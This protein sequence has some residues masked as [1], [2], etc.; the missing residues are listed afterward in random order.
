VSASWILYGLTGLGVSVLLI[1]VISIFAANW[2][3]IPASA[4]LILYFISLAALGFATWWRLPMAG[5]LKE[6]LIT[7]FGLYVLAGIGLIGQ[8][9]HLQSD[10]YS[11]LFLW[12][13]LILP[14]SLCTES[15]LL[16]NIWFIGLIVAVSLWLG[17]VENESNFG[18]YLFFVLALPHLAIAGGYL[19]HSQ[20]P[21]FAEAA[22]IWGFAVLLI[23]FAIC[24]NVVWGSAKSLSLDLSADSLSSWWRYAPVAAAACA[25][26]CTI[27]R[28]FRK[29]WL[30]TAAILSILFFSL[31]LTVAPITI[32]RTGDLPLLGCSLFI[33]AWAGA[34]ALAAGMERRRLFDLAA[35]VIGV[36]FVVVYF[37][38]FGSLAATGLGLILSGGVI[39]GIS[40]LW[41]MFRGRV[42]KA[43]MGAVR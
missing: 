16:N 7:A 29:G 11:A 2:H 15:R 24:G 19:L 34:A 8:T 20:S 23:P 6:A 25:G 33:L 41:F 27:K 36:R 31:L 18:P 13:A 5:A 43:L 14:I 32:K 28:P 37:E 30:L 39:L 26:V 3:A 9:Y 42:Q 38:V 40:Y 4:K 10:G 17:H 12:L 35:F 21:Y 1:G 22:R